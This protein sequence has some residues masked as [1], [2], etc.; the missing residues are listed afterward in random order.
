MENINNI[1]KFAS[2]GI[3]NTRQR[4]LVFDVLK[5]ETHAITAEEIYT[6][7][8][9]QKNSIS[10]STI[11]R[12]LDVFVSK[13][14]ILKSNIYNSKKAF[15]E[16]NRMEHKHYLICTRCNKNLEI[17]HCPLEILEKSL[18]K[19][20]KYKIIGHKLDIYGYC[21]ECQDEAQLGGLT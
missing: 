18:A 13:S 4:D 2:S 14:L 19:E 11:Y 15:Y 20:T 12:I 7:L 1:E 16:I 21:P 9:E 10:L 5:C 3:K 17:S 6:R 8:T